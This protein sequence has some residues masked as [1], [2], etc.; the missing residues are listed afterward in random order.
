MTVEQFPIKPSQ[1]RQLAA[2]AVLGYVNKQFSKYFTEEDKEDIISEVVLRM[3]RAKDSFDS[4][5]GNLATWV[6]TIARNAVKSM[7]AA[8][9]SRKDISWL[10]EDNEEECDFY[11]ECGYRCY[12][13]ATD[14]DLL[15]EEHKKCLFDSL[16]SERD[17]RFLKWQMEGLDA[18]EMARKE[19][20]SKSNVHMILFHMRHRLKLAS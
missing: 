1:F 16:R 10:I 8:K 18:E 12:E 5:K 15:L 20:I 17:R 6:G 9:S 19:G 13:F 4:S 2:K 14:R 3:W 7:A 11:D